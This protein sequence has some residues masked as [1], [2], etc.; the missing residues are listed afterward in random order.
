MTEAR[1]SV[2]CAAVTAAVLAFFVGCAGSRP[3]HLPPPEYET[4]SLPPFSAENTGTGGSPAEPE[5]ALG[6]GGAPPFTEA[7]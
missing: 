5:A 2:C 1:S 3:R 7:R 4:P 6:P